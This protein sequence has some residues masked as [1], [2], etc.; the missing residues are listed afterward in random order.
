MSDVVE[1]RGS[2][3]NPVL[4][5]VLGIPAA[6]IVAGIWTLV[7]ATGNSAVDADPDPV[8]RTAQVQVAS[9]EAD[10]EASRLGLSATAKVQADGV[11]VTLQGPAGP[12]APVLQLVHPLESSFDRTLSLQPGP[13]GWRSAET[14]AAAH[15]WQLRLQ[16][17]DGHWRLV[18]RYRPGDTEVALTP[19]IGAD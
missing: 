3:R 10:A 12:Q 6:T 17:A 19:A 4:W 14:L 16:A 7:V 18:G 8:R 11:V 2:G 5:L 1:K 15:G 9:V 13:D